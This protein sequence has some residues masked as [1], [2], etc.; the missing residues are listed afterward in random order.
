ML[1]NERCLRALDPDVSRVVLNQYS[2]SFGGIVFTPF[3]SGCEC[4]ASRS[5][6]LKRYTPF[7]GLA[8]KIRPAAT[9]DTPN[10]RDRGIV[11]AGI[12]LRRLESGSFARIELLRAVYHAVLRRGWTIRYGQRNRRV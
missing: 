10:I 11:L 7:G 9:S 12:S 1:L 5:F 3:E 4:P 2:R 8:T 6:G